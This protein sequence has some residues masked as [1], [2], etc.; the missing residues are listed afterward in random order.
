MHARTHKRPA[1]TSVRAQDARARESSEARSSARSP[2]PHTSSRQLH[3]ATQRWYSVRTQNYSA[4]T[5]LCRWPR[6]RSPRYRG[7]GRTHA[8]APGAYSP[9][10]V[11]PCTSTRQQRNHGARWQNV[12]YNSLPSIWIANSCPA[13]RLR[14]WDRESPWI[15]AIIYSAPVRIQSLSL[16]R[17]F[18]RASLSS[19]SGFSIATPPCE[20]ER[21][22]ASAR[23]RAPCR[24]DRARRHSFIPTST[25]RPATPRT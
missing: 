9:V 14:V 8:P 15:H 10:P 3:C 22:S 25:C 11:K 12:Q 6:R 13:L 16:L 23:R 18:P 17:S 7:R 24:P 19:I 20:R 1:R 21:R 5:A 2:P 4:H